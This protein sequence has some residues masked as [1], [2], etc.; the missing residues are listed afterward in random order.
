MV[1]F[2]AIGEA[3]SFFSDRRGKQSGF[4]RDTGGELGIA[5]VAGGTWQAARFE[6]ETAGKGDGVIADPA[7]ELGPTIKAGIPMTTPSTSG[8]IDDIFKAPPVVNVAEGLI[9]YVSTMLGEN[10]PQVV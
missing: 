4:A 7:T 6:G 1:R 5:L 9:D 8:V 2:M 10:S 3:F